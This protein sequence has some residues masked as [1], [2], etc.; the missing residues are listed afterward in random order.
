ME[1]AKVDDVME[2]S[3]WAYFDGK[4]W[5]RVKIIALSNLKADIQYLDYGRRKN[6]V[7]IHLLNRLPS[8]LASVTPGIAVKCHLAH[9]TMK[10]LSEA[11]KQYAIKI[12]ENFL[13][14]FTKPTGLLV[15]TKNDSIGIIVTD[16]K[17]EKILNKE[18]VECSCASS[19][20]FGPI[21]DDV[22]DTIASKTWN[23][24]EDFLDVKVSLGVSSRG[25]VK[26]KAPPAFNDKKAIKS[27]YKAP[28]LE[29]QEIELDENGEF[30]FCTSVIVSPEE[31]YVHPCQDLTSA[32]SRIEEDLS[33]LELGKNTASNEQVIEG[34]CW[35]YFDENGWFR[36][37]I[38]AISNNKVDILYL[39]YGSRLNGIDIH[40][41][42]KLPS[43][44]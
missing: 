16:D 37:K 12:I 8:G 36:V 26:V 5:F 4:K 6:C 7:D 3:C 35:A 44:L 15:E 42:N 13:E 43:G 17:N 41:L 25:G 31:I 21:E 22:L 9:I 10:D 18:M 24:V 11:W 29:T 38:L 1:T 28:I 33:R 39:D 23:P 34:S 32:L 40:F 27:S 14:T 2:G 30:Q 20:F 19:H